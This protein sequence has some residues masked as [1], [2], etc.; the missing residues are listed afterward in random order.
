[1]PAYSPCHP[2][3]AA[4]FQLLCTL[5]KKERKNIMGNKNETTERANI[6]FKQLPDDTQD[7]VLALLEAIVA[8]NHSERTGDA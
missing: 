5:L 3:M 8:D 2:R 4:I 1:M 7:R 6:L